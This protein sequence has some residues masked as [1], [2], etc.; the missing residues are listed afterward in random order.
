MLAPWTGARTV[1]TV[2]LGQ[3]SGRV[4]D[5]FARLMRELTA[6]TALT[7]VTLGLPSVLGHSSNSG[8]YP[9]LGFWG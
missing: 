6:K 5:R 2:I 9:Y 3:L 4:Q 1:Q 7:N 8:V